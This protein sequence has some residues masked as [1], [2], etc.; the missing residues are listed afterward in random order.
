M[1][2]VTIARQ[3]LGIEVAD[4]LLAR[5]A[6]W[7][8]P[9]PQPFLLPRDS[10]LALLGGPLTGGAGGPEWRDTFWIYTLA[11]DTA[12]RAISFAEFMALPRGTRSALV[13]AQRAMS[14][15]LVPSVR[16]WPGLRC[17]GT[18]EQAD[19]HRFVWW[20]SLLEGREREVLVPFIEDGRRRSRHGVVS[21]GV[22]REASRVLP[23]ARELA[24]TFPLGS[25][26]NCFGTVMGAAGVP[27]A[28]DQWMQRE[29]FEE[30]LAA[31][32]RPGGRDEQPG[33]VLVWRSSS[34][35]IQHAAV[36]VGDGWAL[37][38]PSQGWMSPTK[39]LTVTEL[40][41]SARARD[42]RLTRRSL[43]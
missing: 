24:G 40:L 42:R 7:F 6:G 29:P 10:E 34:G 1:G 2:L 20:S 41:R 8:A 35:L 32:T 33:T 27:G 4:D 15:E 37:H 30:W 23:G 28:A 39:V 9:D 22:W 26:P 43:R 18:G 16:A 21:A 17:L 14:R 3:V 25:G 31:E 19:G 38:K 36:T 13:R 12:C 11:E 5:W